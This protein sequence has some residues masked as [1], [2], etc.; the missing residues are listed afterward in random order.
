M[1]HT[2]ENHILN[3][4]HQAS[5]D[6][7]AWVLKL[8]TAGMTLVL[9][10]AALVTTESF[11]NLIWAGGLFSG[12]LVAGLLSLRLSA[13]GLRR[14]SETPHLKTKDVWQFQLVTKLNWAAF[15]TLSSAFVMLAVFVGLDAM[16]TKD[17]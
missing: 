1:T 4:G 13:D 14:M 11:T 9:G 16:P 7:D 12:S 17:G 15:V 3:A 5:Q 6:F 8:G 2:F 10:V